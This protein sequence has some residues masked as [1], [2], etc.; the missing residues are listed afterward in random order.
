MASTTG[1]GARGRQALLC[2]PEPWS[3]GWERPS[4]GTDGWTAEAPSSL[5]AARQGQPQGLL[6]LLVPGCHRAQESGRFIVGRKGRS[7]C[8]RQRS[9]KAGPH[10]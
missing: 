5:A 1:L 3:G 2:F 8:R 10:P 4:L 7:Q 6:S 9:I